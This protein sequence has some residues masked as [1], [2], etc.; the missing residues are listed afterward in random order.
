MQTTES[1]REIT[2]NVHRLS[3]GEIGF[4]ASTR[5]LKNPAGRYYVAHGETEGE[6]LNGL[7]HA[8][9]VSMSLLAV[10]FRG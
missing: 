5:I 3:G 4:E 1:T 8:I 2:C 10:T 7:A 9:G 6:A